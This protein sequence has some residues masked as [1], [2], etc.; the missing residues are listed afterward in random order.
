MDIL[1]AYAGRA[2]TTRKCVEY[3]KMIS[4]DNVVL[5]DTIKGSGI[6]ISPF[7]T[8]IIGGSIRMST[9]DPSLKNF[10]QSNNFD[11]FKL[12]IFVV[13]GAVDKAE[14]MLEDNFGDLYD[15]AHIKSCFGGELSITKGTNFL[16]RQVYKKAIKACK[17]KDI[18]LPEIRYSVIKKFLESLVGGLYEDSNEN[19][20]DIAL[21]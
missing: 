11:G 3:I 10:I 9:I 13:C 21:D 2:G 19:S 5:Y 6:E 4:G 17:K 15:T 8:I 7:D 16:E 20:I 1:V 18:P 14:R 12:G